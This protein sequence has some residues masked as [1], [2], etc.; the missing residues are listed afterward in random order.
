M[1]GVLSALLVSLAA[2]PPM[3]KTSAECTARW[4]TE[5]RALEKTQPIARAQPVLHIIASSCALI[6][7]SIRTRLA[8][9]PPRTQRLARASSAPPPLAERAD[10]K[11]SNSLAPAAALAHTCKR[12]RFRTEPGL[13]EDLHEGTYAFAITLHDAF[14]SAGL[15]EDIG[16]TLIENLILADAEETDA[17][18]KRAKPAHT[19]PAR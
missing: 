2:A 4:T 12:D 19:K 1:I 5:L 6:P 16:R 17:A 3:A 13:L 14:E 7:E 9:Q 18:R 10:C 8:S 11:G 15:D